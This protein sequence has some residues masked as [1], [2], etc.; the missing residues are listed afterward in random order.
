M[1]ERQTYAFAY[2]MWRCCCSW[3]SASAS[4][5]VLLSHFVTMA[6]V[7]A[8]RTQKKEPS[9][10]LQ[11]QHQHHHHYHHHHHHHQQQQQQQQLGGGGRWSKW[12]TRR[13]TRLCFGV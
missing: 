2:F 10:R 3:L 12:R 7:R 13:T 11:E 4:R 8:N 5:L 1:F 9:K 6:A